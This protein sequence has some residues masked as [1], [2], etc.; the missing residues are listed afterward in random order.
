M[1]RFEARTTKSS[2]GQLVVVMAPA[3]AVL[4]AIQILWEGRS[5][6]RI[7]AACAIVVV[8]ALATLWGLRHFRHRVGVSI[9]GASLVVDGR[10]RHTLAPGSL[11]AIRAREHAASDS[12]MGSVVVVA[13]DSGKTLQLLFGLALPDALYFA[14]RDTSADLWFGPSGQELL[15]RLAPYLSPKAGATH[16]PAAPSYGFRLR[17]ASVV[18]SA[19]AD[20]LSIVGDD[21]ALGLGG[22]ILARARASEIAF[23][24]HRRE[25]V[26]SVE[27]PPMPAAPVLAFTFPR[28]GPTIA[29][30]ASPMTLDDEWRAWPEGPAPQVMVGIGELMRLHQILEKAKRA[31]VEAVR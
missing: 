4:Y 28:G 23:S 26:Q 5:A 8:G 20:A 2:I 15:D 16:E 17:P 9:D 3:V 11:F 27:G 12:T 29:V 6:A 25:R 22:T 24:C 19:T 30:A 31:S 14:D 7:A 10:G 1:Q 21:V 13:L 18:G